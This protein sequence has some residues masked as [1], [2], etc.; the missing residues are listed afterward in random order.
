MVVLTGGRQT[1]KT[2]TFRRPFPN[3]EFVSLDLPT[4]AGLRRDRVP[5]ARNS[6]DF[7]PELD[8]LRGESAIASV[9]TH[10]LR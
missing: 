2:S 10:S 9:Q 4:V 5:I 6:T 8:N 3:H 1:G 7:A